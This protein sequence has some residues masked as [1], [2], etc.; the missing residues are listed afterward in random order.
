MYGITWWNRWWEFIE[1]Y[2]S[3]EAVC[4]C[5][6]ASPNG[7]R[8]LHVYWYCTVESRLGHMFLIDSTLCYN[9]FEKCTRR[10]SAYDLVSCLV[11]NPHR[12][13]TNSVSSAKVVPWVRSIKKAVIGLSITHDLARKAV[14]KSILLTEIEEHVIILG[15]LPWWISK[16]ET[17]W[18]HPS[19]I[20]CSKLITSPVLLANLLHFNEISFPIFLW[21]YSRTSN[22]EPD[23]GSSSMYST[24]VSCIVRGL[25]I[26][27]DGTS[28]CTDW[29]AHEDIGLRLDDRNSG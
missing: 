29:T 2:I 3:K 23:S 10:N 17:H 8:A 20:K 12:N 25:K 9:S 7:C 18:L 19:H 21:F 15:M 28:P 16:F 14:K 22:S 6:T 26:I 11:G 4:L 5:K 1:S 13:V 24:S 27:I